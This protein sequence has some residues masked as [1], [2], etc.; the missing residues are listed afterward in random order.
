MSVCVFVFVLIVCCVGGASAAHIDKDKDG[1]DRDGIWLFIV[2][3]ITKLCRFLLRC[4]CVRCFGCCHPGPDVCSRNTLL[5]ITCSCLCYFGDCC[6][7]SFVVSLIFG[8]LLFSC[9]HIHNHAHTRTHTNRERRPISAAIL[10]AWWSAAR[11]QR[12]Q[13]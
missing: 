9:T 3:A 7:G 8:R 11:P 10:S 4:H 2:V 13:R 6:R 1:K 12:P 5:A